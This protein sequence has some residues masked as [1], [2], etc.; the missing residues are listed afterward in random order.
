MAD[1]VAG[2]CEFELAVRFSSWIRPPGTV[3]TLPN[4]V[5]EDSRRIPETRLHFVPGCRRTTRDPARFDLWM[6]PRHNSDARGGF[7][8]DSPK[9]SLRWAGKESVL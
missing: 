1:C 6:S 4:R 3:L 7:V 2:K 5:R 9:R 8:D